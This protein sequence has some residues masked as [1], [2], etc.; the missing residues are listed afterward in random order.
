MGSGSASVPVFGGRGV[1]STVEHHTTPHSTKA[2]APLGR[3]SDW[4][5]ISSAGVPSSA[6]C[7]EQGDDGGP[8]ILEERGLRTEPSDD[9]FH[10]TSSTP[11]PR[12]PERSK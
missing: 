11:A 3:S 7:V 1:R 5:S 2:Q 12:H 6:C 8:G 9:R 4:A 10:F